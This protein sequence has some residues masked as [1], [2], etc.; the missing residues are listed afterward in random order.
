MGS[1]QICFCALAS[2]AL[3][4]HVSPHLSYSSM[5]VKS[6]QPTLATLQVPLPPVSSPLPPLTVPVGTPALPP[7]SP[8]PTH[9]RHYS[10]RGLPGAAM[11][12]HI[13][14]HTYA[15]M[16]PSSHA[17]M[18]HCPPPPAPIHECVLVPSPRSCFGSASPHSSVSCSHLL[19]LPICPLL[20][21]SIPGLA[22]VCIFPRSRPPRSV[23]P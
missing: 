3:P 13:P 17:P 22:H 6:P 1:G 4:V 11:L 5:S 21:L 12:A 7:A 16:H 2:S 8:L 10:N 23:R 18:F 14:P 15:P 9:S 20:D 19:T